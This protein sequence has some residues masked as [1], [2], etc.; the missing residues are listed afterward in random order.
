[1]K[2]PESFYRRN[3]VV[4]ISRELLGK[5]L[6]TCINGIVTG[7]YIVETEAYNGIIDKA[8]HS[9][10]NRLT[11]RTK[12]MYMHGGVAYVYLCY[13]IH[14]MFNVVTAVEGEPKAIL[15]RAIQPTDGTDIMLQRRKMNVIKPAITSGPG[16][17]ARALGISRDINAISLLSDT[18]WIED[19][20]MIIP[21]EA[22]AAVPRI[23]VAYAA[24]DA[25]LP[26]R[27]YIK[28]NVYVSKPNK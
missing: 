26:Y 14:E 10:G 2:L 4:T 8:A 19:R 21:D 11:H 18:L 1:M 16:S 5:Y 12:T 23:G 24:E 13:G 25:Q 6:F 3:D 27:F 22:I 15:I 28:G 20:G 9:Y 7:G 17:V